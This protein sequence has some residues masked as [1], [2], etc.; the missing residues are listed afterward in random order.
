[1]CLGNL[2]K[3]PKPPPV[4][5]MPAQPSL[6]APPPPQE[7]PQTEQVKQEGQETGIENRRKLKAEAEKIREGVK[8]FGAIDESTMPDSPEGGV[9]PPI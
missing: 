6:K 9:T 7:T 8:Q 3:P 4:Q 1:M 2:F 5:R